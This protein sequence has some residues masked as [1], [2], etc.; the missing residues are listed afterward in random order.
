MSMLNCQETVTCPKT[1]E[2]GSAEPASSSSVGKEGVE[3]SRPFG[4][5]DLNRARLPFRHFP[6]VEPRK[7]ITPSPGPAPEYPPPGL[8]GDSPTGRLPDS[9][10]NRGRY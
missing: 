4:H 9:A 10:R 8:D 1:V 5:T 2:A 7:V 3:P 6:E